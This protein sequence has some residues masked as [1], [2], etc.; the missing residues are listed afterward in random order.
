MLSANRQT[1]I[2]RLQYFAPVV[3]QKQLLILFIQTKFSK[4]L[5]IQEHEDFQ[6]VNLDLHICIGY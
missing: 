3:E 2:Q 5:P 6:H 4:T 1:D